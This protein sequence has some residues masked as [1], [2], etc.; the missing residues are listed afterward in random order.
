M[1]RLHSLHPQLSNRFWT[2]LLDELEWAAVDEPCT[3]HKHILALAR[4]L[5]AMADPV[6]EHN[7]RRFS[8]AL[9]MILVGATLL[10]DGTITSTSARQLRHLCG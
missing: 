8:V 1:L 7:G 5:S 3:R 9:N 10:G 2:Y 4:I 6:I